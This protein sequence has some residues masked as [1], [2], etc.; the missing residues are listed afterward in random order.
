MSLISSDNIELCYNSLDFAAVRG[1]GGPASV[2]VA[3]HR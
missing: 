2:A 1:L 3:K